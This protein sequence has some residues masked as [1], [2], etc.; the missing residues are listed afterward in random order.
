MRKIFLIGGGIAFLLISIF[1][2]CD[3]RITPPT[4]ANY[5]IQGAVIKNLDNDSAVA[6]ALFARND[7][8]VTAGLARIGKDTLK[9]SAGYFLK[10]FSHADSI[11]SG[12]HRL[13]L[14]NNSVFSDSVTFMVPDTFSISTITPDTRLNPGGSHQV[15][16]TW[17][18]S[19]GSN[20]YA[21]G[22]VKRDSAY[23]SNGYSAF[24]TTLTTS[25]T[26]P[27]DAFRLSGELDTGW[28]Y[29]YVYAYYGTP[30]QV[31]N[32]P[33]SFPGGLTANVIKT[34]L[35]GSWGAITVTRRDSMQVI[36]LGL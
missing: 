19:D 10:S 22:V 15:R 7:T 16:I 27:P 1:G 31:R 2:G 18:V 36:V 14:A 24:V 23:N 20:G 26:I 3:Q 9:Y 34:D 8:A 30:A 25:V 12:T 11:H 17:N 4:T 35:A 13:N 28:Y 29:I 33:T 32:L 5:L 21:Y 6:S